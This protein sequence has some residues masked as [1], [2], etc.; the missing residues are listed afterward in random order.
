MNSGEPG[1]MRPEDGGLLLFP[2]SR[3]FGPPFPA[4]LPP[5]EPNH[6]LVLVVVEDAADADADAVIDADTD[7]GA[8]TDGTSLRRITPALR[9]VRNA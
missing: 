9:L 3:S 5:L 2:P 6:R 8:D 1:R 4:L 7:A